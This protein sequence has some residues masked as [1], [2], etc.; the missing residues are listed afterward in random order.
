MTAEKINAGVEVALK[1]M[2]DCGWEAEVCY[3]RPDKT[4]AQT[5]EFRR[6]HEW[7]DMASSFG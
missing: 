7:M 6:R 1:Q 5:V 3:I 4:V 2:A